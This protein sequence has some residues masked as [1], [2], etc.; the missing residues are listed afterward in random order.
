MQL[1]LTEENY[2]KAIYTVQH[3]NE[4]G[5]VSVNEIAERLSTR[6]ATVTDML[7]KLSEKE[8]IHYEKYKKVQ[9]THEGIKVALSII[10]KH[11]LWETFLY[12]KLN[13]SWDE[14][15]E[16]AEQLEHVRSQKLTDRLDEFLG[17]PAF[18]PH[19]DPIPTKDGKMAKT[20]ATPLTETKIGDK[21]SI[22]SVNDTSSVFL[23]Q[24]EIYGLSIGSELTIIER[25]PYD[26]SV[27]VKNKKGNNI[28]LS[29]KMAENIMVV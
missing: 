12:E 11:R 2:V 8:L 7:R 9:L 27:M 16:V 13:F 1:T 18:D 28:Q 17:F 26:K 19:G 24:L 15:H 29:E 4:R 5:E 23:Q 25:M 20:K 22:V 6:P 3:K 21:T 14:V 10:R